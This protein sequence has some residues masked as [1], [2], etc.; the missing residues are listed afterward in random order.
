M[1][2]SPATWK[3]NVEKILSEIVGVTIFVDDIGIPD[4][5][6]EIILGYIYRIEHNISISKKMKLLSVG[7][8]FIKNVLIKTTIK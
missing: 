2:G 7:I 3:I 4:E 8:I 1:G 6:D 5:T